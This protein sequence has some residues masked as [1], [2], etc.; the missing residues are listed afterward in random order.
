MSLRENVFLLV[1]N[2]QQ[3]NRYSRAFDQLIILLICISIAEIILESFADLRA[4]YARIFGFTELLTSIIFSI[5]YVL[6]LWTADFKYPHLPA[7]RARLK[8]MFSFAGIIDLLA[9]LPFYLP[10][11]FRFDLRVVRILR[12]MRLL[13]IFKLSRYTASLRLVGDIF[14][15]KR[16][17]IGV[18]L[19]ITFVMLLLASTL[20]Y[21]LEGDVQPEAFPNIIATFWW[22]IA[23]LTTVGYGDVFPV[24][25]CG[26]LVSGVI[27][28]LGI[29]L[30]ALP[31]GI[32]SA[33]FVE[34][35]E[36]EKAAKQKAEE[37]SGEAGYDFAFCPHCGERL[38]QPVESHVHE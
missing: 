13:R 12:V 18:T 17:E 6:R 34:K 11:I 21:Y 30:V 22:A 29:G 25:G 1:E 5:E 28:L 9:I 7:W 23:T 20:M 24:Q 15:E 35:L 38:P 31:T 37:E 27:A 26:K 36:E 8:F 2:D 3:Q 14:R 16:G 32:I 4:S 33:A 19:F 10:L